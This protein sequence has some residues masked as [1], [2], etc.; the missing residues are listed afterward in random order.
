MAEQYYQPSPYSPLFVKAVT[1]RFRIYIAQLFYGAEYALDPVAAVNRTIISDIG[2]G[3]NIMVGDS[4]ERYKNTFGEFPF[5]AYNPES[6]EDVLERANTAAAVGTFYCPDIPAYVAAW[7]MKLQIPTVSFF[8]TAADYWRAQSLATLDKVT[9]T[10]FRAPI[11]INGNPV[12]IVVT[13]NMQISKG[14]YA[15]AFEE[16]LRQQDI[17]DLVATFTLEYYELRIYE[18]AANTLPQPDYAEYIVYEIDEM[19]LRLNRENQD[20]DLISTENLTVTTEVSV[21]SATP[22]NNS[23]NVPVTDPVVINF[24]LPMV[25]ESVIDSLSIIPHKDVDFVW[26]ANDTTLTIKPRQAGWA[27]NKLYTIDLV[28]ATSIGGLYEHPLNQDFV[29]KFTTAP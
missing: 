9:L 1:D 21:L 29:L 15:G 10:R 23:T 24:S 22:A 25:R 6:T 8:G 19:I 12:D 11:I 27:P 26:S 13:A 3:N 28:G 17:H 14:S 20:G 7:P 4:V 2:A 18:D 16:F 5:T